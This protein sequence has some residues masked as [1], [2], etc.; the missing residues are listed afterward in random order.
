MIF[1]AHNNC[2]GV[3]TVIV[4]YVFKIHLSWIHSF[5]HS[6]SS[7]LPLRTNSA[8]FI[9]LFSYMNTKYIHHI[10]LHSFFPC[11]Q[12]PSIGTYPRK[13][14]IFLSC[15][16]FLKIKCILIVQE[17]LFLVLKV[18]K[19]HAFIKLTPSPLLLTHYHHAPLIFN[20]LMYSAL[21]YIHIYMGCFN[22]FHSLTFSFSL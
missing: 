9:F 17:D 22:I 8:G 15:P 12:P 14:F 18:C 7:P 19:Y 10:C 11:V 2:T 21:Y 4:T 13:I 1:L 6:L 3:Y 16:S 5:H 20:S